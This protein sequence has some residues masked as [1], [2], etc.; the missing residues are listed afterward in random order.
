MKWLVLGEVILI[1]IIIL[2]KFLYKIYKE[3]KDKNES[4]K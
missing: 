2:S 1:A 3:R 4:N